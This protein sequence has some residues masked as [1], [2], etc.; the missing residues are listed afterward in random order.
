[1]HQYDSMIAHRRYEV[2]LAFKDAWNAYKTFAMGADELDPINCRASESWMG[3]GLTIIDSLDTLW[4]MEEND[5]FSLAKNWISEKL[6]FDVDREQSVFEVTIRVLGGLLSAHELSQD[7]L[8]LEKA[9]DL[10]DR[11]MYAFEESTV[12]PKDCINLKRPREKC[13]P[14]RSFHVLAEVGSL[15]VEFYQLSKLTG[16]ATYAEKALSIYDELA[17]LATPSGLYPTYIQRDLKQGEIAYLTVGAMADSFYEYL[18]KLYIQT[19]KAMYLEMYKKSIEGLKTTL[20]YRSSSTGFLYPIVFD[21]KS[22][23]HEMDHLA[24]FAGGMLALGSQFM[25]PQDERE[26]L[27]IAEGLAA[28]CHDLYIRQLTGLSP[29]AVRFGQKGIEIMNGAYFLRPEAI[30][31]YFYL[32]RFTGKKKYR[33]WGWE[34]FQAIKQFCTTKCGFSG[35]HRVDV[36]PP[37]QDGKMES[38]F[39]AETLKYLYLLFSPTETLRLDEYI[40]NTEAHPFRIIS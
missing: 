20:L 22:Q 21:G 40:L 33:E 9:I 39:L 10:A 11:L 34:A 18:L 31:T 15:Q 4:I 23:R 6:T 19:G 5:E 17:K 7:S 29:D 38:F 13:M 25:D 24:C 1:M 35:L 32:W 36:K 27:N 30:E 12:M 8:F 28:T 16:N 26:Q 3:L 2:K 14:R 37:L